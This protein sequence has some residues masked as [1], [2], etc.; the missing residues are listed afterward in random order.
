MSSLKEL[1]EKSI[2][3]LREAKNRFKNPAILW[4]I[5]KDSTTLIWLCKKAFFSEVPFRVIHLDT[6]YKFDEIYEFRDRYAR[7]WK[8][9][10]II[11]K[12]ED[13]DRSGACPSKD[14]FECCNLRKT[15]NLKKTIEKYGFDAI[16]AGIRRDEHGIRNKERYFSPR[17]K[18]SRWN[19]FKLKKNREGDSPLESAQDTEFS[20][21]DIYAS[22]FGKDTQHVRIH[23][24]LHWSELDIWEYIKKENIPVAKLYY[25]KEGKRYRSIGC[26]PCCSPVASNACDINNIID[27]LK[28]TKTK[29]RSGRAQDKEDE[30][31]MQRLRSLGYM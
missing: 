3:I 10:L 20:G 7:E 25:S 21:W 23:P 16:I 24:L 31:N 18:E 17:D 11:A 12:N 1:E 27:E 15:Q 2:Y 14:R 13:A 9:D 29:E 19:I 26:E 8:L 6:G 28:T 22:D 5:G 4:S 30:Y